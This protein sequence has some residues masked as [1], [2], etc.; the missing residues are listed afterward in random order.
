MQ[1]LWP[2]L[3]AVFYWRSQYLLKSFIFMFMIIL[4]SSTHVATTFI[5]MW[6][7]LKEAWTVQIDGQ[8]DTTDLCHS[9]FL[10]SSDNYGAM[11]ETLVHHHY[12]LQPLGSP[13]TEFSCLQEFLSIFI[14]IIH[15]ECIC[16]FSDPLIDN[17]SMLVH[18]CLVN[19]CRILHHD[20]SLNNALKYAC[21][22]PWC[23]ITEDEKKCE[24]IIA[25]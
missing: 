25:D 11:C 18:E 14:D 12:L 19:E 13:I 1:S 4:A 20:V 6:T 5:P 21:F 3:C 16:S 22:I 15:G 7:V 17:I 8:D 9:P 24:C 23:T 10:K 2:S